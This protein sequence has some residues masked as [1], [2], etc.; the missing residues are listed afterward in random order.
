MNSLYAAESSTS[1]SIDITTESFS[2]T[3]EE[4]WRRAR[5][6]PINTF[7]SSTWVADSRDQL[8]T[9]TESHKPSE[10]FCKAIETLFLSAQEQDF[11]DGVQSEFAESLVPLV[12]QRGNTALE[13]IAYLIVNQKVGTSTA[14]EALRCLGRIHHPATHNFRL[15]L[16]EKSLSSPSFLI[17]DA[18]GLGLTSM[19]DPHAIPFLEQAVKCEPYPELREDLQQVI[20]E[21]KSSG[22]CNLL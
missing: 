14:V 5:P 16:L 1:L 20:L 2:S 10:D 4:S 22:Q 19:K 13:I 21:L 7:E 8:T 11:E 6:Q 17:R 3:D 12:K 18:A 9:S 15:W